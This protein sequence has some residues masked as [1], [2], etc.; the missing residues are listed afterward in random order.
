M[1]GSSISTGDESNQLSKKSMD[2]YRNLCSSDHRSGI[3]FE[4]DL[5]QKDGYI[6]CYEKQS[7]AADQFLLNTA[8]YGRYDFENSKM[9]C[10]Q[11]GQASGPF[12]RRNRTCLAARKLNMKPEKSS[13]HQNYMTAVTNSLNENQ[14]LR[15]FRDEKNDPVRSSS[16][17]HSFSKDNNTKKNV[18]NSFVSSGEKNCGSRRAKSCSA[19]PVWPRRETHDLVS[20]PRR[21]NSETVAGLQ[22]KDGE[23]GAVGN[24]N[25]NGKADD[26][27]A[28]LNQLDE[29]D[30]VIAEQENE[31]QRILLEKQDVLTELSSTIRNE[32]GDST[33]KLCK[34]LDASKRQSAKL[35]EDNKTLALKLELEEDL[36]RNDKECIDMLRKQIHE[37]ED[38]LQASDRQIRELEHE[39]RRSQSMC[40][41][42]ADLSLQA[43]GKVPDLLKLK[44][45]LELNQ[46]TINAIENEYAKL[47]ESKIKLE[48][49]NQ[50]DQ[51]V[52]IQLRHQLANSQADNKRKEERINQLEEER[53]CLEDYQRKCRSLQRRD[54]KSC[55]ALQL[56]IVDL[57]RPQLYQEYDWIPMMLGMLR[58]QRVNIGDPDII[59]YFVDEPYFDRIYRLLTPK[60]KIKV[61]AYLRRR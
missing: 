4:C 26:L 40:K 44:Y 12:Q 27:N 55:Y 30:R 20:S 56:Q 7:K 49:T 50:H 2:E 45:K 34:E 18:S 35:E 61:D 16:F 58:A 38:K 31:L 48:K 42:S 15:K 51:E 29:K 59:Q 33:A 52:L 46:A 11:N 43:Q 32:D 47:K 13:T 3:R 25:G 1:T 9:A 23:V 8:C 54:Q 53:Q 28:L 19:L 5:L 21:A 57:N 36:R 22:G 37:I 10:H 17:C 24:D 6:S 39:K 41:C 14:E 60:E